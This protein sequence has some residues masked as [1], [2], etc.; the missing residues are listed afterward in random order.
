LDLQK[1]KAK[2]NI[3]FDQ[4]RQSAR[5]GGKQGRLCPLD[6]FALSLDFGKKN[7][8]GVFSLKNS[9]FAL[10][11]DIEKKI[12]HPPKKNSELTPFSLKVE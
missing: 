3:I 10:L 11:V 9:S 6:F 5:Q 12:S 2:L 7:L 1:R 4:W 8:F